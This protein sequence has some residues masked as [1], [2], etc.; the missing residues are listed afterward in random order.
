LP[1]ALIQIDEAPRELPRQER[2]DRCLAGAHEAG[3]TNHLRTGG[4][5]A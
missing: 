2:A 3:K 5:A 1:D 4:S